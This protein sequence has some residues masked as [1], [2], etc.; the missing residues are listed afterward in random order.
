MSDYKNNRLVWLD[1]AKGMAIILVVLGHSS[2]PPVL[3]RF[4]FAFHMP[5]FFLASGYTSVFNKYSLT[6]YLKRKIKVLIIPFLIYSFINLLLQPYVSDMTYQDYWMQFFHL[7]WLGVPLWFVPVLFFSL[8]IARLL[9]MIDDKK[10]RW[11]V[12]LFMPI[13]SAVLRHLNI[14]LPWNM[15]VLPYATFLV[16]LGNYLASLSS[17]PDKY[18]ATKFMIPLI[19]V[20]L[21]ITA[22][23][24][25]FWK[26]DM[27]W[28]NIL[29]VL[30]LLLGALAGTCLLSLIAILFVRYSKLVTQLLRG[31]G[32]ETYL[33][34]AFAELIIVYLNYFFSF[35]SL[36]KYLLLIIILFMLFIIKDILTKTIASLHR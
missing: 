29:P 6:D 9:F 1:V 15:S 4:I 27:C 17:V 35:N 34:L 22:G 2:L 8:I 14:W 21:L 31:I 19:L 3:N 16:L 32:K 18:R 12:T 30:P 25:Y 23:V 28:N 36:V 5:F 7:G 10:L 26:L 13:I 24:S 20:L 11:L 33:I